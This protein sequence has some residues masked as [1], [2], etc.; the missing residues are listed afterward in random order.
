MTKVLLIEDEAPLRLVIRVNLEL[1]GI[2]VLEAADGGTGL[3]LARAQEP[4]LILLDAVLPGLDGWQIAHELLTDR[5]TCE[6]PFVFLSAHADSSSR[7][8]ALRLGALDYITKP[9]D[10]LSLPGRIEELL[11]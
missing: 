5:A 2:E 3:E 1:A 6:I 8:R 7:E 9:F 10:P 4:D 11:A